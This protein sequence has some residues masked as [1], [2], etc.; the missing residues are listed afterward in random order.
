MKN[1]FIT[2]VCLVFCTGAA[3]CQNWNEVIKA[4]ASDRAN[5]DFFGNSVS[6]SGDYAIVG[7]YAEAEDALGGNTLANAG[8]AYIY[9]N[10]GGTWSEVQ[11]LV[12]SDRAIDDRFGVSV[13]ISGD[14]AIVG[15][16]SEDEDASGG[17][18]LSNAGSVYIFK[19]NAGTWSEVQKL[20]ASD[21]GESDNF[22]NSV[23]ISGDYVIVS[24]IYE[25]ED[26]SGGNTKSNAGS[27][28]IF[29][30]VGGT[31][32]EVQKLVASDR[33]N[34]DYFGTS[35]SISGD[36]AIVGAYMEDEDAS[37]GDGKS[38][39][40]SAYIFRNVGGTWSEVQKLVASDRHNSDFF[41]NSVSISGDYAIVG[42]YMEDEDVS[43]GNA[44]AEAGSAYIYRNIGG[45]WS[46]VQKLVAS[47][48]AIDDR[49]GNSVSISGD[50][51]IV[52][53][54]MEDE[55]VSGGNTI[56]EAGSA[57]IYRNIGGTWSEVQKLVTS[58]RAIGDE[59][60]YSVSISGDYTIVGAWREDE[61]ASGGNTLAQAGSSYIFGVSPIGLTIANTS[62]L[63]DTDYSFDVSL[64]DVKNMGV[65]EHGI[66][67]STSENP[68]IASKSGSTTLGTHIAGD[69]SYNSNAT[70]TVGPGY[71]VR[72]YATTASGTYY[73]DQVHFGV[74]PTLPEWG[75]II[76]AGGF[77]LAGGWLVFKK[78][79]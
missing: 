77:V 28:Y 21:R 16:E 73:S 48:R 59:F 46:E 10:V 6:I 71:Y 35:V 76:L 56:A 8:S 49:F 33:H 57:Y 29:R 42:A 14:Y 75:L 58:D 43:G 36:Y 78:M 52:G 44:I 3:I 38:S 20:V 40:G 55:D 37:G 67:W 34:S 12:A 47:D 19:N 27:A 66:V 60:G 51:A 11:K 30:N 18:T 50:Y 26:A 74:V 72:A 79:M 17:N 68:T 63:S 39:A 9:R 23:S 22:G 2:I 24:A 62:K 69:F 41:G 7:A 53:A 5:S 25:A 31:W 32:S 61:D 15:A 70:V 4:C 45:V 54:Y 1:V 13:S 64:I 65:T